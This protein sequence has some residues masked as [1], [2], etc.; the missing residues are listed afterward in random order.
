MG[1]LYRV[2]KENK[3]S[4]GGVNR[5]RPLKIY[6]LQSITCLQPKLD[7]CLIALICVLYPLPFADKNRRKKNKNVWGKFADEGKE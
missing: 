6:L 1:K 3:R 7:L 5:I 4:S 2:G